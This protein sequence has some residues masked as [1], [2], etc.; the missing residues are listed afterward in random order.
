MLIVPPEYSR[1]RAGRARRRALG[2]YLVGGLRGA[3]ELEPRRV[4][5]VDAAGSS[6]A[7]LR[8][9]R[10]QPHARRALEV[11]TDGDHHLLQIGTPGCGKTLLAWRLPGTPPDA[12][13][14]DALQTAT[15]QACS[16][17]G[18]DV[19]GSQQRPYRSPHHNSCAKSL[20]GAAATIR[21]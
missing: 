11:A 1:G 12:T 10:G 6:I 4:L 20:V 17:H 16:G 8:D 2:A 13:D 3:G 21:D 14:A 5:P 9:V 18:I 19:A 15:V 7:D